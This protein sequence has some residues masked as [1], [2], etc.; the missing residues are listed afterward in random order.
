MPKREDC[1]VCEALL[2]EE[3][4]CSNRECKTHP[5]LQCGRFV[6]DCPPLTASQKVDLRDQQARQKL[7][8]AITK[9]A[10]E[11][12][13]PTRELPNADQ[14]KASMAKRAKVQLSERRAKAEAQYLAIR[15]PKDN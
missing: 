12:L 4:K 6:C 14:F 5:C 3:G 7:N 15:R 8:R 2:D 13:F 10:N 11:R 1:P 9:A